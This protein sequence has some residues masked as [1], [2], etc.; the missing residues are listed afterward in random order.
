MQNFIQYFINIGESLLFSAFLIITFAKV[1]ITVLSTILCSKNQLLPRNTGN[2]VG[3]AYFIISE[4]SRKTKLAGTWPY[5]IHLFSR[6][7][8]V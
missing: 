1:V 8:L 4:K 5:S 7:A 2:V 6:I 3:K